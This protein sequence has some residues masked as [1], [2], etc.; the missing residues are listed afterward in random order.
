MFSGK[1]RFLP[2]F[3]LN[4]IWSSANSPA[5]KFRT[6]I[7]INELRIRVRT[8]LFNKESPYS[9]RP[10]RNIHVNWR[11]MPIT[12]HEFFKIF[13]NINRSRD[14]RSWEQR[15]F[16]LWPSGILQRVV[17]WMYTKDLEEHAASSMT[18]ETVCTPKTLVPIYTIT[19]IMTWR[20]NYEL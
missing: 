8:C 11:D 13:V 14:L 7:F 9:T 3:F 18:M 4:Y 12:Q 2:F 19:S 1:V 17:L 10:S 5:L 6:I 15:R 20:L 16:I